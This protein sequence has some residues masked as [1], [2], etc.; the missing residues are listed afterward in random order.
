MSEAIY[1]GNGVEFTYPSGD[2]VMKVQLDLTE[3]SRKKEEYA[4]FVKEVEFK[5][6]THRLL[7]IVV[8]PMKQENQK[9]WKTHTVKV[10]TYKKRE[11]REEEPSDDVPF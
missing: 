3:L 4:E 2:K 8:S 9:K 10:D 11:E 5:D 1:I 6:G 7:N